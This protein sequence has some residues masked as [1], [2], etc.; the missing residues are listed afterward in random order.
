MERTNN[1]RGQRSRM[2]VY[3]VATL[4]VSAGGALGNI[5]WRAGLLEP[6]VPTDGAFLVAT[7]LIAS[8]AITV[9]R[10]KDAFVTWLVF[11]PVAFSER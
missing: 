8:V 3:L 10:P 1:D 2:I 4:L 5:V 6:F 7:S 11:L 9:W